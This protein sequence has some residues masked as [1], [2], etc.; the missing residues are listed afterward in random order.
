MLGKRGY[1]AMGKKGYAGRP[2]C[3]DLAP[4]DLEAMGDSPALREATLAKES[5]GQKLLQDEADIYM[6]KQKAIEDLAAEKA[7][8]QK[9]AEDNKK[10]A[11][12]AEEKKRQPIA[13]D[14][15][16]MPAD[17]ILP[18]PQTESAVT[19][20]PKVIGQLSVPLASK[21]KVYYTQI[22]PKK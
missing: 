20:K 12:E 4:T 16:N 18:P 19:E 15:D 6:A 2:P 1:N 10:R 3:A 14:I 21:Q 9:I 7:K 8:Q 11:A 5:T 13:M 17:Y 22:L